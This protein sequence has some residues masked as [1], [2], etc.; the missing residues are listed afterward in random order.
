LNRAA[1]GRRTHA[2]RASTSDPLRALAAR[3]EKIEDPRIHRQRF[4]TLAFDLPPADSRNFR[5]ASRSRA[6]RCAG[7]G[8]SAAAPSRRGLER[9]RL[10]PKR[11]RM[12]LHNVARAPSHDTCRVA[13]MDS[14]VAHPERLRRRILA[15]EFLASSTARVSTSSRAKPA[16][17]RATLRQRLATSDDQSRHA[18]RNRTVRLAGAS[19]GASRRVAE[20]RASARIRQLPCAHSRASTYGRNLRRGFRRNSG[21]CAIQNG[22]GLMVAM[23]PRTP[24]LQFNEVQRPGNAIRLVRQR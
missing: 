24:A 15:R 1:A 9:Q 6:R 10:V 8:Q 21:C 13:A 22:A 2:Q 17:T 19:G 4:E 23:A 3:A 18:P 7:M 20:L 5:P 11:P 14:N 12:R 16:I